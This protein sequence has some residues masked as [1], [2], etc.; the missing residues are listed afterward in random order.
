MIDLTSLLTILGMCAV[1]YA[2]RVIGFL[3]LRNRTLSPR[4]AAVMEAAPGCVLISVIAPNF[5]S[6]RPADLLALAITLVAATR[7]PML[8]TVVI[9]VA[10]A[11]LLRHFMG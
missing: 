6:D 9:G 7:L 8:S 10:S 11:G 1:T 3:A 2:T 4:A 5:V